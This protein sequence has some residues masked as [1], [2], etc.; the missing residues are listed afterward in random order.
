MQ[1]PSKRSPF[2]S[3]LTL[4]FSADS[5]VR[6]FSSLPACGTQRLSLPFPILESRCAIC[7]SPVSPLTAPAHS[8]APPPTQSTPPP[9]TLSKLP[10]HSKLLLLNYLL[11][12]LLSLYYHQSCTLAPTP[13]SPSVSL[14][15]LFPALCLPSQA[16]PCAPASALALLFFVAPA[17]AAHFLSRSRGLYVGRGAEEHPLPPLPRPTSLESAPSPALPSSCLRLTAHS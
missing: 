7:E 3:P 8:K 1:S 12:A 4:F 13:S 17:R 6:S 11:T 9:R 14:P 16:P 2:P 15:P 5:V 10:A